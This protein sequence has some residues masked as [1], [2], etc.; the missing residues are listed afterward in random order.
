MIFYFRLIDQPH[1][2]LDLNYRDGV[3]DLVR[4][5]RRQS[6]LPSKHSSGKI[7]LD[8][9]PRFA[10]A[11]SFKVDS[12][13]SSAK[14]PVPSRKS[15]SSAVSSECQEKHSAVASSPS[16]GK[17]FGPLFEEYRQKKAEMKLEL[18]GPCVPFIQVPTKESKEEAANSL[19]EKKV[20]VGLMSGEFNNS[21]NDGTQSTKADGK[22]NICD[23]SK[24]EFRNPVVH[25]NNT[26]L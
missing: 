23:S 12:D 21:A 8:A 15:S 14:N 13:T 22:V 17:Y 18:L 10:N 11:G 7:F 5:I 26:K 9:K 4:L 3:P 24:L 16:V 1:F 25:S 19:G 2:M 20:E 6:R